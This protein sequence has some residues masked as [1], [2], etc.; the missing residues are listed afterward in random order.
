MEYNPGGASPDHMGGESLHLVCGDC[1][2]ADDYS[3]DDADSG[4]F[5]CRQCS[6]LHPIQATAADPHEFHA[7]GNISVRRLATQPAMT[8]KLRTPAP[9]M[10]PHTPYMTPHTPYLTP[11]A[12]AAAAPAFDDFDLPSGPRDFA[13]SVGACADPEDLAGGIRWRYVRGLQVILQR[14]LEV[15]V[16]QFR[17]GA[18]VCGVAG[19]IWVRWV[20]ASKVLDEM[21]PRQVLAEHERQMRFVCEGDLGS[22]L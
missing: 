5:S 12:A 14:Q 4:F 1:G 20:V 16:E 8:P 22:G 11:H 3:P 17:V 2:Y 10:T 6:A 7:T 13:P 21:W 18:L 9:Y 19:T 15:L